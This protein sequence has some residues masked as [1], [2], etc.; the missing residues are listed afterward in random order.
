[1]KRLFQLAALVV[2]AA[3]SAAA[4]YHFVHYASRVGPYAPI[5][6]KFDLDALVNNTVYFYVSDERPAMAASDTYE[7]LLGQ[8][9][10]ALAAWNNIPTCDLRVSYGGVANVA[11]WETQAPGGEIVFEE[12]PPGVVGMG[13]PVTRLPQTRGFVPIHRSRLILSR[14]L[15]SRPSASEAFFT[16]LVH[17]IGHALGLQH[18]QTGSAMSEGVIRS[19]TRA[20]PLAADDTVGLSLLYPSPGFLTSTGAI[21]G[22]VTTPSGRG[23]HL[24]S[25][26][27]VNPSGPVVSALTAPD[28]S[29]RIEGLPP[30]SYIL[31]AQSPPP[32]TQPGL[33][34]GNLVLPTDDTGAPLNASGPVETQFYG[35]G[36]D[37]HA[38]LPLGVAAGVTFEG[39]DFRLAER[40]SLP[41]Y[42]VTTYSFPGNNAPAV[43][44]AFVNTTR[45]TGTLLAFG[46]GLSPNL[47]NVTVELIGGGVQVLRNGNPTP[48]GPDPRFG[49]IELAFNPF[50]STGSRHLVFSLGGDVYV[51]P[52][53]VQLVSRAAPLVR[54]AQIETPVGNGPLLVLSGDNLGPDS[55]V[56]LDGATAAVRS[57]DEITGRLRVSPPPGPGGRQAVISVYNPDGQSSVFV[58]PAAPLTYTYPAAEPP[59]ITVSPAAGPAGRDSVVEIQGVN[60]NFAEAHTVV[61]FG[62]SDVVTRRVWVLSA[63]RLLAVVSISPRAALVAT[64]VS[65]QSGTQLAALAGGFRVEAASGSSLA[66]VLAFQGLVNAATQQPRVA[67]G[68]LATLYGS[69]LSLAAPAT[70]TLP[71]PTTLAGTTVTLNDQPVPLLA[72]SASQIN[73]QLPFTLPAGPAVLRVHNG[74]ESSQP[75]LVQIDPVAPGLFRAF[76]SGGAV[77]DANN[78][79]RLG[80]TIVLLATGLGAVAPPVTAGAPAPLATTSSPVRVTVGGVEL[81]PSYAGLAPGT[82]GLYQVNVPL[83]ASLSPATATTIWLTVE[84]QSSN[85]LATALR[86]P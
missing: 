47:R 72:V 31:Y 49:E 35:G 68:S 69:G 77:V 74:L 30:A 38:S 85:A 10:Q 59:A 45:T 62:T 19:A 28:G 79:A 52:G 40:S 15:T 80:D 86:A 32:G 33:G 63:T 56:F 54:D 8:V 9:R 75:M 17:E 66:P 64:T 39:V 84:G 70:A 3:S 16:S 13:G 5:Y 42:D 41:V 6:E 2:L 11:T 20:R 43:T 36:K 53:A 81:V 37:P 21:A 25:V 7:A 14:D 57:F 44:P 22:R 67:P 51:R 4:Y 1:V 60:T 82:A 73:M 23:L 83:P 46:T 65:V 61:G 34:P 12:L 26:V 76:S 58:Q 24:V 48:Y 55:R 71:L 18:T 78:P 50:T 27:A 29:Y